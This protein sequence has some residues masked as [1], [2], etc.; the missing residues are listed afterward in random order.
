ME[1]YVLSNL[2]LRDP[3]FIHCQAGQAVT[4]RVIFTPS[5]WSLWCFS[6]LLTP[7]DEHN[8]QMRRKHVF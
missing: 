1:I 8:G 7:C 2:N 5:R 4:Y 3:S 6:D